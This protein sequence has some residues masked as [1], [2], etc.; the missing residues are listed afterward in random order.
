MEEIEMK[1][2]L[3]VQRAHD[4]YSFSH[5][6]LHEYLA[7]C[8]YYKAGR[9]REVAT[10][11]LTDQRWREVHLLLAGLQEPDADDFLLAL[12]TATAERVISVP[13][14]E[15]LSWAGKIVRVDRYL[16]Q[17]AARRAVM[18]GF[19]IARSRAPV[20]D[21]DMALDLAR[22]LDLV[23]DCARALD[24]NMAVDLPRDRALDLPHNRTIDADRA[25]AIGALFRRFNPDGITPA[26][27]R[28]HLL[29][30]A[31]APIRALSSILIGYQMIAAKRS[32]K[33][34][35]AHNALEQYSSNL[36]A[37][38]RTEIQG[39]QDAIELLDG[40][41]DFPQAARLFLESDAL[42]CVEFLDCTQ[43][44]LQCRE[45]AERVTQAGWD[46]V[47]KRLLARPGPK[48][49]GEKSWHDGDRARVHLRLRLPGRSRRMVGRSP[50]GPTD[51]AGS[52]RET[53]ARSAAAS[54]SVENSPAGSPK[55]ID[56]AKAAGSPAEASSA[57]VG[58]SIGPNR[59]RRG[60]DGRIGG[61]NSGRG[62]RC[63]VGG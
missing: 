37:P 36:V 16:Q 14:K 48:K 39:I 42:E 57:R 44:I 15:L 29:A 46:R 49:G 50:I 9:S 30:L 1:Q 61:T 17:T 27:D 47:C 53:T 32:A 18:M 34:A 43:R 63:S 45:A 12:T 23:L 24:S 22:A 55:I 2:G 4:K 5:L 54:S 62:P 58:E 25:R 33:F 3:L 28:T 41:I 6:T 21:R 40:A 13:L 51:R 10:K 60:A 38:S 35:R 19:I 52:R 7:A 8:H 56:A 31:L 59:P 11:T 20:L 26:R